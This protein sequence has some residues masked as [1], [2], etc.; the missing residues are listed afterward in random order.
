[1]NFIEGPDIE[2]KE[3]FVSDVKKGV[4]AF[5][6]TQGGTIYIGVSNDGGIIGLE[7]PDKVLL[8]V[9]SS[10]RDSIKPDITMFTECSTEKISDKSIIKIKFLPLNFIFANA[11]AAKDEVKPPIVNTG[12]TTL[13]LFIIPLINSPFLSTSEYF[14]TKIGLGNN[15]NVPERIWFFVI[16]EVAIM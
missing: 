11:K 8:Q 12:I 9:L 2:L 10:I 1:M 5:A 4:V 7:A 3:I 14:P 15:E 13:I 16:N 6:N